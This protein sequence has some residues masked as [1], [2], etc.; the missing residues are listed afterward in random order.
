[1][2]LTWNRPRIVEVYDAPQLAVLAVL[3]AALDVAAVTLV[4]AHPYDLEPDDFLVDDRAARALL[5]AVHEVAAAIA[6]Y[7]LALALARDGAERDL[8]F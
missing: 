3:E 6:R 2:R 4:A 8:P 7:R 1:M 5:E